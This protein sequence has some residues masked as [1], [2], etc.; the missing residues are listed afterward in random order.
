MN[1]GSMDDALGTFKGKRVTDVY[2]GGGAAGRAL[3]EDFKGEVQGHL[4][5]REKAARVVKTAQAIETVAKLRRCLEATKDAVKC[6]EI[7]VLINGLTKQFDLSDGNK[8]VTSEE[9]SLLAKW[10]LQAEQLVFS[11]ESL[12]SQTAEAPLREAMGRFAGRIRMQYSILSEQP[13]PPLN[14]QAE[15]QIKDKREEAIAA[16]VQ[17]ESVRDKTDDPTLR[18][19]LDR[20][21]GDLRRTYG[22]FGTVSPAPREQAGWRH[23]ISPLP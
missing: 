7:Q 12:I 21:S 15:T 16:I 20:M 14:F 23:S 18:Q 4:S 8:I 10:R 6:Q 1:I 22:I 11:I 9:G 13:P 5:Q 3:A 17:L 19:E 2:E